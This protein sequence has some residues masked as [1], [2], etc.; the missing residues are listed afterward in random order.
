MN[1]KEIIYQ[2]HERKTVLEALGDW[3]SIA[4]VQGLATA[5][6]SEK[7]VEKFLKIPPTPRVKEIDSLIAKV[8]KKK[9]PN[10]FKEITDL[11]GVRF[12][13]LKLEDVKKV[14]D[15]VENYPWDWSKDKDHDK[16]KLN[17]PDF[18]AYQS[19]H[20]VVETLT[21]FEHKGMKIPSGWTCEIQIRTLLQHAYA[22]MAHDTDYKP[23]IKLPDDDQKKVRRSLAKGSALIE[24]TD[25]VFM[26][27]SQR[28][29][30]YTR[31]L[32]ELLQKA[33]EIYAEV[34]G[35]KPNMPSKL[36]QMIADYYRHELK[37][38]SPEE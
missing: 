18:F 32:D 29:T 13:V 36:G 7:E 24:T 35:E 30:K 9:S 16:D 20:Y 31:S 8:Y 26:E 15:I 38:T 22:E 27:I 10:P 1:E 34:V 3:V 21:E 33:S 12:V 5:L 25:E 17:N 6:G 4:I 14:G 23:S 28:L 37:N 19:D 11:V 2:Y